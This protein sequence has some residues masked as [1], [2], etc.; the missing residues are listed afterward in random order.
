LEDAHH[1]AFSDP[2]IVADI[3]RRLRAEKPFAADPAEPLPGRAVR[4]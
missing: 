1:L 2:R 3:A 4:G